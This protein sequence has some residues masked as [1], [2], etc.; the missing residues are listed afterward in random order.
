MHSTLLLIICASA[1]PIHAAL[2]ETS[3]PIRAHDSTV[4]SYINGRGEEQTGQV[5]S[6][7]YIH[8]NM[9]APFTPSSTFE[10]L[11]QSSHNL[12]L[13]WCFLAGTLI[14]TE[15]NGCKVAQTRYFDALTVYAH[16]Y[17]Y[18]STDKHPKNC[19]KEFTRRI[20]PRN[21]K[22]QL[23]AFNHYPDGRTVVIEPGDGRT[24]VMEPPKK[25][26]LALQ[27]SYTLSRL[28]NED[29]DVTLKVL[30]RNYNQRSDRVML[31]RLSALCP[32]EELTSALQDAGFWTN[33]YLN[34]NPDD[35]EMQEARAKITR[36]LE[37]QKVQKAKHQSDTTQ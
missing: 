17:M 32:P 25:D 12:K 20:T 26:R 9:R 30:A 31:A 16:T 22:L 33:S 29:D 5:E 19:L 2:Q 4:R 37:S 14:T 28:Y 24:V 6:L 18:Q 8:R 7:Y 27:L 36:I 34:Y 1:I 13:P 10:Q 35:V 21:A 23:R 3:W 15:R 11:C